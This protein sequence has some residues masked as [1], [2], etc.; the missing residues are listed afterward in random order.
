MIDLG[1]FIKS[2]RLEAGFSQ[3]GLAKLMGS[4]EKTIMDIEN[5]RSIPKDQ[6]LKKTCSGFKSF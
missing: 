4:K 6:T 3:V 1:E 2:K 5:G